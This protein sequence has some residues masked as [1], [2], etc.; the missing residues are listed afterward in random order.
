MVKVLPLLSPAFEDVIVLGHRLA[1]VQELKTGLDHIGNIPQ[2]SGGPL[3]AV[4]LHID[5][6]WPVESA[7]HR[8]LGDRS[9]GLAGDFRE[10]ARYLVCVVVLAWLPTVSHLSRI[11]PLSPS[12]E[13]SHVCT[14]VRQHVR[15][16]P[17]DQRAGWQR[18]GVYGQFLDRLASLRDPVRCQLEASPLS[19]PTP[20]STL[21]GTLMEDMA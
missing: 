13:D 21:D 3:L 4:E 12:V 1:I 5:G 9:R 14:L 11:G 2:K 8:L 6:Q 17:C 7:V 20:N 19:H 15:Q 18:R 16:R 10:R